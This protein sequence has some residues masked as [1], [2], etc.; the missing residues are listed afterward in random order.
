MGVA[1]GEKVEENGERTGK[2]EKEEGGR[3]T[4]D[5]LIVRRRRHRLQPSTE[6]RQKRKGM[7]K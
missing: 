6:V 1:D 2:E 7:V 5:Y 4:A 3:W